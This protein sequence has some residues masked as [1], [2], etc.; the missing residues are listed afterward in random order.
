MVKIQLYSSKMWPVKASLSCSLIIVG[1]D[2]VVG[3][4]QALEFL[5][6]M[7]LQWVSSRN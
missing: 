6:K 5:T 7:A 1:N 4:R 2:I 3:L